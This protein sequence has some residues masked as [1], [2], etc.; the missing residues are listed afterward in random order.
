MNETMEMDIY[1]TVFTDLH[2]EINISYSNQTFLGY[3]VVDRG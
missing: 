1:M 3:K 2:V